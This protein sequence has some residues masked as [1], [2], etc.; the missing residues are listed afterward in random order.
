MRIHAAL[1]FHCPNKSVFSN[2]LKRLYDKSGCL[3]SGG[4]CSGGPAILPCRELCR[5][6]CIIVIIVFLRYKNLSQCDAIAVGISHAAIHPV[7]FYYQIRRVCSEAVS[8]QAFSVAQKRHPLPNC[9]YYSR[10]MVL[11]FL[12]K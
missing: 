1:W 11:D 10:P 3:R 8:M 2:S 12:Y 5:R 9:L 7:V 6:S 4:S